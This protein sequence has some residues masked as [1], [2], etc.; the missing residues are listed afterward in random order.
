MGSNFFD[1]PFLLPTPVSE[2]CCKDGEISIAENVTV[3]C[4]GTETD[5][6]DSLFDYT[7]QPPLPEVDFALSRSVLAGWHLSTDQFPNKILATVDSSMEFLTDM[8]SRLL[9]QFK[10]DASYQNMF[11]SPFFAMAAWKSVSSRYLRTSEPVLLV[12]NS[13]IPLVASEGVTASEEITMKIAGAV[14]SLNFRFHL[15]EQLRDWVGKI[16]SLDILVSESLHNYNSLTTLFPSRRA[17]TDSWCESL[18]RNSGTISRKRLTSETFPLAWQAADFGKDFTITDASGSSLKYY[19]FASVDLGD[20]DLAQTW[21]VPGND[22]GRFLYNPKTGFTQ[23]DLTEVKAVRNRSVIL[24]GEGKEINLKTRVLKLG[25]GAKLKRISA[26]RLRGFYD[27]SKITLTVEGSRDM[28][29]W[30]IISK[31]KGGGVARI[32]TASFRFFRVAVTG[33]LRNGDQLHGISVT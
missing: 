11:V 14:C 26:V 15:N 8:A 13:R 16:S 2:F 29:H 9:L 10:S 22:I 21:K 19:P 18:D 20:V 5:I 33:V 6:S 24:K 32:G 1:L 3:F 23:S 25:S 17:T 4:D 30:W 28:R 12:P 27:D 31:R 7:D